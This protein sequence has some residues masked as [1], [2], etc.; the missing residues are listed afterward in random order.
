M[1]DYERQPTLLLLSG[2]EVAETYSSSDGIK[3]VGEGGLAIIKSSVIESSA[4]DGK[5]VLFMSIGDGEYSYAH[6]S[7]YTVCFIQLSS[8]FSSFFL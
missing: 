2:M 3:S 1:L 7:T 6:S 8:P 4:M 5:Q